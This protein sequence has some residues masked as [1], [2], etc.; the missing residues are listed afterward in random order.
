MSG[1]RNLQPSNGLVLHRRPYRETSF[2][3]DFFTREYGRVSVVCRGVR[4]GKSSNKNEKK[5]LLQPFQALKV[6]LSG[7]HELKT[8]TQID[9]NGKMFCFTGNRLFSALYLNELLNRILPREIVLVDIYDLYLASLLR[10]SQQQEIEIILREFEINL[11]SHLGYGFSWN[12]D[13]LSGDEIQP[14]T[15]YI[16]VQEQ[17]FQLSV[18][19]NITQNCFTSESLTKIANAD[20]DKQSLQSAK[21]VLRMALRPLLGEKPLKSREL[22]QQM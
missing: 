1:S 12:T 3:V 7:K 21:R 5:S 8:L 4:G 13:W 11:L 15:N 22:F 19:Q 20:W 2:I 17:G 18:G 9:S 14:N 16:Y 6:I 10:L